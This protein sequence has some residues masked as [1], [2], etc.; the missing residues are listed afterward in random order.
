ML[1]A[2]IAYAKKMGVPRISIFSFHRGG[3]PAGIPPAG[4]VVALRQAAQLA[5]AAGIELMIEPEADFWADTCE[6]TAELVRIIGHPSLGVNFDPCNALLAGDS[7]Y[8][9]GYSTIRALIRHVHFKNIRYL[10]K[11]FEFSIEGAFPWAA[12]I[13]ALKADGYAGFIALEPHME[14]RVES[15][16]QA[17]AFLRTII[18]S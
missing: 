15:C 14:P 6:R 10:Q 3:R 1:P 16:R 17:L 5:G 4:I 12:Q 8:P 9:Q 11:G 7:P 2:A 13:E 18:E